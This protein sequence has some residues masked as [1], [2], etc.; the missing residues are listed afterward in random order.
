MDRGA[1]QATV[2]RVANSQTDSTSMSMEV[3]KMSDVFTAHEKKTAR[4]KDHKL[5]AETLAYGGQ[6]ELG[7]YKKL[8]MK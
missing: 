8:N 6:G 4:K 3:L 1:W 2:H 7:T 5:C